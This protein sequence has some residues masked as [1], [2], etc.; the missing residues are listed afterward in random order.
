MHT[1]FIL[2]ALERKWLRTESFIMGGIPCQRFLEIHKCPDPPPG[3]HGGGGPRTK[4]KIEAR[5]GLAYTHQYTNL[6]PPLSLMKP[7]P[8]EAGTRWAGE[9]WIVRRGRTGGELYR[10]HC[11]HKGFNKPR[12]MAL[13]SVYRAG[14]RCKSSGAVKRATISGPTPPPLNKQPKNHF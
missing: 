3:P 11:K 10:L 9:G 12:G 6:P 1:G 8:P 2:D 13:D 14:N 7:P 5:L 4:C